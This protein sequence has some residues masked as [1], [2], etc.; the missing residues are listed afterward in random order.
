LKKVAIRV[1]LRLVQSSPMADWKQIRARI[2]RAKNGADPLAKL[3]EL[4]TKTRDAMVAWELAAL[5]EKTG[6]NDE[7]IRWYSTA[8]ERFRRAEWKKKAEEALLRLGAPVPASSGAGIA[9][10]EEVLKTE[11]HAEEERQPTVGEPVA[12]E[13]IEVEAFSAPVVGVAQESSVPGQAAETGHR[14]RRRGRRGGR[15]R[16]RKGAAEPSLPPRTFA[17]PAPAA[18]LLRE[19]PA[20]RFVEPPHSRAEVEPPSFPERAAHGRAGEPALASRLAHLEALL[21]RLISSPLHRLDEADEAPAGPGVYLLSDSD[22]VT[23]YYVENC[24][25][26]RVALGHLARGGRGTKG[27][28][29]EGSVRSRLAEHLGISDAKVSQYLKQ[30]CLVRWIQLDEEAPHLAHFAIAVLKPPLSAA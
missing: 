6:H 23:S 5:E 29:H 27:S 8:A 11:A 7:A 22:L 28:P 9:E 17:E 1:W 20:E 24:K 14:K 25:T 30:H 12:G 21:R 13:I 19:K 10:R 4:F 2:H 16:R 26:L 18:P 3:S 15:G